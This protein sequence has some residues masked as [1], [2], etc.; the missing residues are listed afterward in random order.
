MSH[1][2]PKKN[3]SQQNQEAKQP[4]PPPKKKKKNTN[5]NSLAIFCLTPWSHG[6]WLNPSPKGRFLQGFSLYMQLLDLNKKPM[7]K[8]KVLSPQDLC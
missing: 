2:P 7:E 8:M 3:Q 4:P 6:T 5:K 1:F